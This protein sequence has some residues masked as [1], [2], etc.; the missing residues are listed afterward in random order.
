VSVLGGYEPQN[1]PLVV[2]GK[3]SGIANSCTLDH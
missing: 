2:Y 1:E 3:A